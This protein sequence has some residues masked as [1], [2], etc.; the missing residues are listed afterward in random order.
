MVLLS[1][2]VVMLF[3]VGCSSYQ[4]IVINNPVDLNIKPADMSCYVWLN[5]EDPVFEEITASESCRMFE[6]DGC[7]VLYF[8]YGGC[9]YCQRAVPEL[10]T[11]AKACGVTIYYIDVRNPWNTSA[12]F[13][14]L[15]PYIDS[16]LVKTPEGKAFRVPLVIAVKD[17]KV[18]GSHLALVDG[19]NIDSESS[20][21]SS[22]QKKELRN[23]YIELFRQVSS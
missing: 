5:D 7:G 13:R 1:I 14:R 2:V 19:Y 18:V 4:P 6:E 8:G 16:A 10:N 22:A 17:G 20:Q 21:M 15:L 23:I 3:A 11:A 9:A 12:D